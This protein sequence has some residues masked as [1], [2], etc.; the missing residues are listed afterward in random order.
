MFLNPARGAYRPADRDLI[1]ARHAA[2]VRSLLGLCPARGATPILALPTPAAES[3]L[4]GVYLKAEWRRM[5]LSSFKALGGAY[6]VALLTM[7]RAEAALGR[8]VAAADLTSPPVRAIAAGMTLVC[9]SAG[10]HGLSVAAGAQAFGA[11][12][13]V[14]LSEAVSE[15]FAERLRDKGAVVERAGA[16]YEESMERATAVAQESGW[17]LVSDSS[18]AGYTKTPL[19]VMRGYTA[20]FEEAADALEAAGGPGSHVFVQAGVGGLAAAGAGYL[21]DRWGEDFTFVVVEP[22]GAPCVRES[23]RQGRF[24][25]L[26]DGVTTLGRLD[27]KEP[28]LLAFQLLS[29]LA[30]AF[31][32]VS[33]TEADQAAM[34]LA[35]LGAPVSACGAAGAAGLFAVCR[36]GSGRKHLGLGARSRVLL[37]G[38]EAADPSDT[39]S[40]PSLGDNHDRPS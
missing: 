37:I 14:F 2:E 22:E 30:D 3:G 31:V 33:D 25:R 26:T 40:S 15:T 35:S 39:T 20:L 38:T 6:A 9:A 8:P 12:A 10:N 24:V 23:V 36:D 29:R 27:C 21:R 4:A 32:L 7:A 18:W 34:R 11:R 17:D 16:T 28:S 5:G 13:V 19:D 1:G